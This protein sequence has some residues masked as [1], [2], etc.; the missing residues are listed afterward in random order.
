MLLLIMTVIITDYVLLAYQVLLGSDSQQ[1]QNS[2]YEFILNEIAV[3]TSR[4]RVN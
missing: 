3:L 2:Y 4:V 1:N